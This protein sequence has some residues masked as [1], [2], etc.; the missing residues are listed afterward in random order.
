MGGVVIVAG[1]VTFNLKAFI[2]EGFGSET[3]H[4]SFSFLEFER[5]I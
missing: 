1:I 3:L 5:F 4:F 2:V